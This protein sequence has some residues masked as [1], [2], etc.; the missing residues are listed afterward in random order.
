[1]T[2]EICFKDLVLLVLSNNCVCARPRIHRCWTSC[3][4]TSPDAASPTPPSTT[5]EW[6]LIHFIH[7]IIQYIQC[8]YS[9]SFSV[10]CQLCVILEP[11][12]ELMSRH[13]TYSLSPR[14][15]LKTCLFQ[16]WQRMVA[17]PGQTSQLLLLFSAV[18]LWCRSSHLCRVSL[19]LNPPDRH[20]T[21]DGSAR[22]R[23]EAPWAQAEAPITT[24]TARRKVPQTASHCPVRSLWVTNQSFKR[25]L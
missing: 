23:V 14:D 12:Q 19:Q 7:L 2:S 5:S 6:V 11:M 24:A 18:L 8:S 3:L 20:Q 15:C 25:F 22:C 9:L 1:M 13:K 16:K 4:K 17:P 10:L 21:S